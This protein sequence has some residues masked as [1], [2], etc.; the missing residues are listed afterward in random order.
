MTRWLARPVALC[1]LLLCIL[2]IIRDAPPLLAAR[3]A[4]CAGVSSPAFKSV[5]TDVLLDRFAESASEKWRRAEWKELS[6]L[7]MVAGHA[8]F[9]GKSWEKQSLR[10][11]DNWILEP[12]Q[13]GQVPTFLKHI[14]YGVEIAAND[15]SALLLF[16][17]GQ[18][19]GS[20]GPRSEGMTYWLVADAEDWYGKET[21]RNRALA[22]EYARDSMENLLFSICRFKQVVGRYPHIIKVISFGFKEV[23]FLDVH[24]KALRFPRH[25]FEFYGVDPDGSDGMRGLSAGERAQAMGP[26]V[27]DPYGCNA[28]VL[29]SK[30]ETRNPYMRYH[31]YPQGCPELAGL[32]SFCGR[33]IYTGPLPWDPRVNPSEEDRD[34]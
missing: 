28:P 33:S 34:R 32:F 18:T 31:P 30:K 26:F 11:E 1:L 4:L 15:S 12:F 23:R 14:Q 2:F 25:R 29:S 20:A 3:T 5:S 9:K 21:V 24:R 19:R 17:G 10:N 7:V 22:E 16:S 13:K 27:G 8:I 6:T